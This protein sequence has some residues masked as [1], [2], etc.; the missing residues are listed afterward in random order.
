MALYK[1]EF[2]VQEVKDK[3]VK[4]R[5]EQIIA[6]NSDRKLKMHVSNFYKFFPEFSTRWKKLSEGLDFDMWKRELKEDILTDW[7]EKH[8]G[9]CTDVVRFVV[10]KKAMTPAAKDLLTK[11]CDNNP[12]Q[13]YTTY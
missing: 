8:I 11:E 7:R 9:G 3:E 10:V 12:S 2:W 4:C 1:V 13:V 6:S 5:H